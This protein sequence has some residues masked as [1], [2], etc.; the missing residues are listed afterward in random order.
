MSCGFAAR[1][2][3]SNVETSI[4]GFGSCSDVGSQLGNA[5][6]APLERFHEDLVPGLAVGRELGQHPGAFL[7]LGERRAAE[8]EPGGGKALQPAQADLLQAA[9]PLVDPGPVSYTHLTLPT[10][11]IV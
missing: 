1:E 8:A 4:K 6:L 10:K 5:P 11:R 7:G 3:H 2:R 9:P